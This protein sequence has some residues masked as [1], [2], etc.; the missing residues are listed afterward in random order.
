M[1]EHNTVQTFRAFLKTKYASK[2]VNTLPTSFKAQRMAPFNKA[3]STG[4][5]IEQ[6]VIANM[7]QGATYRGPNAGAFDLNKP[8]AAK[9][10]SMIRTSCFKPRSITRLS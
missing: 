4:L 3:D 10:K 2:V 9:I 7:E 1:A 6:P 5:R 8:I